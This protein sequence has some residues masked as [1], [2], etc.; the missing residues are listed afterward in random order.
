MKISPS[1]ELRRRLQEIQPG[2]HRARR[3]TMMIWSVWVFLAMLM[4]VACFFNVM[5]LSCVRAEA[6]RHAES[7]VIVGGHAFLSDDILRPCQQPFENEGRAV[8]SR[9]ATVDYVRHAGDSSLI[10]MICEND[11]EFIQPPTVT[12]SENMG[13]MQPAA[14]VPERI[15]VT[16]GKGQSNDQLRMFF[17]GL[18]GVRHARLGVSAAARIEHSPVGFLPGGNVTIP[19]LPFSIVDQS[20]GDDSMK[21]G[22][23]QWSQQIESGKG[24]DNLSWNPEQRA[25]ENGPDGLPEITLTLSPS[26]SGNKPDSLVPLK[27]SAASPTGNS[28]QTVNW[29]QHGVTADDLKT[30]GL[31]QLTFPSTMSASTLSKTECAEIAAWLQSHT[32]Q[33]FIVCL[34]NSTVGPAGSEKQLT[35]GSVLSTVQLHRAVAARIM[36]SGFSAGGEVRICLQPCVLITSTAVMSPTS[37]ATSNRYVYSVRLCD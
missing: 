15:R 30:L 26:S 34:C 25:V 29:M 21:S 37:Q 28:C 17:S 3:G 10:P 19:V 22:G 8:R 13:Q 4:I 18:T 11:V 35:V 20:Y 1:Q 33:S 9:N 16:F 2:H 32:G 7:A 14:I 36:A 31:N 27:F 5:W 6:R 23:G 24:C 12:Q